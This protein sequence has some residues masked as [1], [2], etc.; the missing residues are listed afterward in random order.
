LNI[1][2]RNK[3]HAHTRARTHTERDIDIRV[4]KHVLCERLRIAGHKHGRRP[5]FFPTLH[6][7]VIRETRFA[8]SGSENGDPGVPRM[9][10]PSPD[11][12]TPLPP[13]PLP[14]P[15]RRGF[16]VNGATTG[17]SRARPHERASAFC[18]GHRSG[19][20]TDLV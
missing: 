9:P 13:T 6:R 20:P 3:L 2:K 18:L 11:A 16:L 7:R 14:T 5:C 19:M 12:A 17:L 1:I 15:L 4:H 10:W 8:P